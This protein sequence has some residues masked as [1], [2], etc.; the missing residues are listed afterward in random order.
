MFDG[1]LFLKKTE[2]HTLL[3]IRAKSFVDGDFSSLETLYRDEDS[4]VVW[5]GVVN[6]LDSGKTPL[7]IFSKP[8]TEPSF[9]FDYDKR[10]FTITY[11]E[12]YDSSIGVCRSKVPEG[13]YDC[14]H[15][16][17][18]KSDEGRIN[19]AAKAHPELSA[20]YD[21]TNLVVSYISNTVSGPS[22][23]FLENP[24][25][26]LY[27][28]LFL[29]VSELSEERIDVNDTHRHHPSKSRSR[30]RKSGPK[31]SYRYN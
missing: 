2:Y 7:M 26:D 20:P 14:V 23:L 15:A 18:V 9:F 16:H 29:T 8:L 11:L 30:K 31:S 19:Y 25:K 6:V 10:L 4:R 17:G 3:R 27:V 21:T 13:P 22:D 12:I 5:K 1:F 28:P 24:A